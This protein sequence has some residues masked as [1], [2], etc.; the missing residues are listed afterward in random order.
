MVGD[1][2]VE[3]RV[4]VGFGVVLADLFPGGDGFIQVTLG[5]IG[6]PEVVLCPCVGF[7]V[8]VSGDV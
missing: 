4:C 2:E 1:P 5:F 7:G 3:L 6:V 8:V